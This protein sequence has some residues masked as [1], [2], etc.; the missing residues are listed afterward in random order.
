MTSYRYVLLLGSGTDEEMRLRRA[1]AALA[2]QGEILA[3]S[4]VVHASSV[5]PGDAHRYVN[6]ALLYASELPRD[7]FML[8]LKALEQELGRMPQDDP[9]IIDIDLAGECGPDGELQW[10]NPGKL[11]HPLFRE[12][13]E[14]VRRAT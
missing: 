1:S 9:C 11:E 12:L 4:Q 2:Q 10:E 8:W 6:Q 13:A 5:V 14:Q 7:V 3:R